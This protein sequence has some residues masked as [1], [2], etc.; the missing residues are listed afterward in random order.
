MPA[1]G[2]ALATRT[3]ASPACYGRALTTGQMAEIMGEICERSTMVPFRTTIPV[4]RFGPVSL[5]S[6]LWCVLES[7]GAGEQRW[8]VLVGAWYA[9]VLL[10]PVEQRLGTVRVL[11]AAGLAAAAAMLLRVP[12]SLVLVS[13]VLGSHVALYCSARILA[14]VPFFHLFWPV[15]EVPSLPFVVVWYALCVS[16][17]AERCGWTLAVAVSLLAAAAGYWIAAATERRRERTN[18]AAGRVPL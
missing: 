14:Y 9:Y 7:I 12:L 16:S 10:P 3:V 4:R 18:C 13:T 6:L 15:V 1:R 8:L 17:L 2:V 5:A 11:L